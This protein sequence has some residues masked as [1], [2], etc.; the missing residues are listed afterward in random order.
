MDTVAT[1]LSGFCCAPAGDSDTTKAAA[2]RAE[3]A[4]NTAASFAAIANYLQQGAR[5][6]YESQASCES[7]AKMIVPQTQKPALIRA[8]AFSLKS[9]SAYE[10]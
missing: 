7:L 4:R 3:K 6:R 10:P 9:W 2:N 5:L 8:P 1:T